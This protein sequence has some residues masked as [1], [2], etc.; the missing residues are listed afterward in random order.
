MTTR[1]LRW[2]LAVALA[3]VLAGCGQQSEQQQLDALRSGLQY[4]GYRQ[5]SEHGLPV[6]FAAYQR[7]GSLLDTPPEPL[8]A[9]D[10][11]MLHA[12][13]SYTALAANKLLPAIAEA[14]L[15]ERDCGS[16]GALIATALR[17]MA[18]ERKHWPQLAQRSSDSLW[19][20]DANPDD[21][22]TTLLMLHVVMA[23]A[24]IQ[25]KRWDAAVLHADAIGLAV[26]APWLGELARVGQDFAEHRLLEGLR[27]LKRLSEN[28]NVPP[29]VRAELQALITRIEAESG[30]LDSSWVIARILTR[31]M[32]QAIEQNAAPATRDLM[33]FAEQQTSKLGPDAL[34]QGWRARW[35]RWWAKAQTF[36][37]DAAPASDK[38]ADAA[39]AA[40]APATQ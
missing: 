33:R 36:R 24:A 39:P 21:T 40:P 2:P 35:T 29:D 28:P 27:R 32:W 7:G 6:A 23:Y 31:F 19:K 5:F 30:D 17:S 3:T 34:R 1:M 22:L 4:R 16:Q 18:F 20:H 14:D 25:D 9:D 11:C 10:I 38:D 13:L 8:T 37:Q 12:M 26:R 15:L